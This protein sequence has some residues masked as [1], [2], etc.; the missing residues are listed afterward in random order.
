MLTQERR[1]KHSGAVK[2]KGFRI[3]LDLLQTLITLH[4]LKQFNLSGH[5]FLI[6]KMRIIKAHISWDY[7]LMKSEN[8]YK[9]PNMVSDID[10]RY[11]NI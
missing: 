2:G 10:V 8:G 6:W 11:I 1:D 5:S 3:A 7:L 9:A 4:N